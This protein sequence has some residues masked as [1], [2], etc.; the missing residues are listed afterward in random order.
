[1]TGLEAY[2][3]MQHRDGRIEKQPTRVIVLVHPPGKG[4][5]K[6]IH[7]VIQA[8][9]DRFQSAQEMRLHTTVQA[10]LFPD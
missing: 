6:R 1:M 5:D 10:E 3:Q 4:T 7:E 2:G 9:R 8:Y